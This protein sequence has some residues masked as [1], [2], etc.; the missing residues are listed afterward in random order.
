MTDDPTLTIGT[1]KCKCSGCDRYFKSPSAFD[2]HQKIS[3][4]G[5]AVCLDP[6]DRGL[7]MNGPWWSW[8][9]P[10]EN[11]F[12]DRRVRPSSSEPTASAVL[13]GVLL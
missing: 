2:R 8:P 11:A 4:D 9:P 12:S 6:A 7:V 3:D 1:G 13:Q 5:S 10:P